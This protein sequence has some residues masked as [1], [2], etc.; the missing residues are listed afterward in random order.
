MTYLLAP[1]TSFFLRKLVLVK[2]SDSFY[3]MKLMQYDLLQK[4]L[5]GFC[6]NRLSILSKNYTAFPPPSRVGQNN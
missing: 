6:Y 4:L 1:S 5:G 2:Q 3:T